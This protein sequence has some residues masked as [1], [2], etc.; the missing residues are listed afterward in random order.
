MFGYYF[1]DSLF[2]SLSLI[3]QNVEKEVKGEA[4]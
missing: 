2:L 3:T 1:G 4:V